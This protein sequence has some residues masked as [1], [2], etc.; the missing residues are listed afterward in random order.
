MGVGQIIKK[1][2]KEAVDSSGPLQFIE[3]EVHSAP[4]N[5]QLRLKE[6]TKLI[7]PKEFISVSEHLTRHK[8]IADISSSNI[9]ESMTS[10]G[11]TAHTHNITALTM[12]DAQIEFKDELK[13]GDRV[14]VAAIQGG[15][16]FFVIDRF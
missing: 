8:R 1:L 16:S 11:Y 9:A 6:N 7:I 12:K 4:P 5:I 13:K 15:Q 10:A 3:A 14:M 2:A